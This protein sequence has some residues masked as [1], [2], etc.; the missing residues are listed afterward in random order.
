MSHA[1]ASGALPQSDALAE[2]QATSL[3]ELMSRDPEGYG[4]QDLARIV[5]VLR[6]QRVRW[7]ASEQEA[8]A[9]GRRP[10]GVSVKVT[11]T[12]ASAQDLGL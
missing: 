3:G 1:G 10:R 11:S 5:E 12:V 8:L 7:K 2:A 4:A 9:T 6:A